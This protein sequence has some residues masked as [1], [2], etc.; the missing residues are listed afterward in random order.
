MNNNMLMPKVLLHQMSAASIKLVPAKQFLAKQIPTTLTPT[1]LVLTKRV[2][3]KLG[4]S[5]PIP[6]SRFIFTL[7]RSAAQQNRTASK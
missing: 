4:S 7:L 2:L 5:K 1:K 6:T 3:T